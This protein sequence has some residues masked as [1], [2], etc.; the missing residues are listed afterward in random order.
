L[1][2]AVKVFESA[3]DH[4][5]RAEPYF[6]IAVILIQ[7]NLHENNDSE[8]FSRVISIID[9]G[10]K[11]SDNYQMY[12]YRALLYLYLGLNAQ[13]LDDVDKAIEKS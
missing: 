5:L 8:L 11:V 13:A 6:Y 9:S 2:E 12:Y 1:E 4:L 7:K 3:T 10:L